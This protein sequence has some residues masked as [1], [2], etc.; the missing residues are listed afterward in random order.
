MQL[1]S[2]ASDIHRPIDKNT[3]GY[4]WVK[5]RALS[6]PV[7][8]ECYMHSLSNEERT[9]VLVLINTYVLI[10]KYIGIYKLEVLIFCKNSLTSDWL[11]KSSAVLPLLSLIL[12]SAPY[13]ISSLINLI[14]SS[15]ETS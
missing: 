4:S 12:T 15:G 1:L 3:F 10:I 5:E 8:L 13:R 9:L 7:I 2:G 14:R 6:L 11:V